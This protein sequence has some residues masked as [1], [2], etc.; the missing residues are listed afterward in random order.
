MGSHPNQNQGSHSNDLLVANG[1]IQGDSTDTKYEISFS[2]NLPSTGVILLQGLPVG[3]VLNQGTM[4]SGSNGTEWEISSPFSSLVFTILNTSISGPY[5]IIASSGGLTSKVII[6]HTPDAYGD[7]Y[8]IG[9]VSDDYI[10]GDRVVLFNKEG[11]YDVL[12]AG[13]GHDNIYG[14]GRSLINSNGG[15]DILNGGSGN[16]TLYGDGE[17]LTNSTGGDDIL[18]GGSGDDVLVG[19][20][21]SDTLYGGPSGQ[22]RFVFR[23][24]DIDI[25]GPAEVD[26]IKDFHFGDIIDLGDLLDTPQTASNLD[27]Y[28]SFN[29]N[30]LGVML[31]VDVNLDGNTN[32]YI[33]LEGQSLSSL[34][35]GLGTSDIDI[36]TNM[37]NQ[38]SLNT[39]A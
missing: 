1:F 2:Q 23:K 36:L 35:G 14:E 5:T 24:I 7:D 12:N 3:T 6:T 22:D 26:V 15:D 16:D 34:G 13:D 38:N 39:I 8:I 11:G 25:H 19:G 28:L 27:Q 29:S 37:I 10:F 18:N 4:I 17:V 33:I 32:H 21:G 20:R 30:S 9:G 31:E